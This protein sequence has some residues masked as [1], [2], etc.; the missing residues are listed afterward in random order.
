MVK[1]YGLTTYAVTPVPVI[2]GLRFNK[3]DIPR[4]GTKCER[5][6]I[7]TFDLEEPDHV[8][9]RATW[10]H[11]SAAWVKWTFVREGEMWTLSGSPAAYMCPSD[12]LQE[13]DARTAAVRLMT[14]S[15][16]TVRT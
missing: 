12:E 11:I 3:G 1:P 15:G 10:P 14:Q 4:P 8:V 13:R 2:P 6:S 7:A 16:R 9:V 5:R